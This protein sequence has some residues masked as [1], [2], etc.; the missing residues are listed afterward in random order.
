MKKLRQVGPN[1]LRYVLGMRNLILSFFI[2]P[3]FLMACGADT[4]FNLLLTGGGA[5]DS[6]SV[7]IDEARILYDQGDY[8]GSAQISAK[9]MSKYPNSGDAAIVSSYAVLGE[10]G[11]NLFDI[12]KILVLSE[13]EASK[14]SNPKISECASKEEVIATNGQA[15]KIDCLLGLEL[16][17]DLFK[18]QSLEDFRES[19]DVLLAVG[20]VIG[21]LCGFFTDPSTDTSS[22]RL[23]DYSR[24][25]C[26]RKSISNEENAGGVFIWALAH[27][28]E[29]T[30]LSVQSTYLEDEAS[31]LSSVNNA[32]SLASTLGSIGKIVSAASTTTS[33]VSE[34][35]FNLEAVEKALGVIVGTKSEIINPIR[36]ASEKID[37]VVTASFGD[38][39]TNSE[40]TGSVI[41]KVDSAFTGM[42]DGIR[43]LNAAKK[44]E[45][46]EGYEGLGGQ[47]GSLAEKIGGGFSCG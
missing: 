40:E 16:G 33:F 7:M 20:K 36:K 38:R 37:T 1:F 47:K 45:F 17:I 41:E 11:L 13:E 21:N 14:E 39:E 35:A 31:K 12:I 28:F 18:D 25:A 9:A 15:G 8:K 24:H 10:V 44:K 43:N 29:A 6:L 46:C 30:V 34:A 3:S 5:K 19:N 22:P 23:E 4:S 26:V 42:Q 32:E 2:V 27:L